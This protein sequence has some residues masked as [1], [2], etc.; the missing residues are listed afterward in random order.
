MS[1]LLLGARW[2]SFGKAHV[3]AVTAGPLLVHVH[4]LLHPHVNQVMIRVS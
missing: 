3:K 2:N 1:C 4:L